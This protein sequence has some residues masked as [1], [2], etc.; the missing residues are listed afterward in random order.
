MSS[1]SK[2]IWTAITVKLT[3]KFL[4]IKSDKIGLAHTCARGSIG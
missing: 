2:F 4:D 1:I 3:L